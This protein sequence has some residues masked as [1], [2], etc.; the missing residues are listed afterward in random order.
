MVEKK[1]EGTKLQVR[2]SGEEM[3]TRRNILDSDK[4]LGRPYVFRFQVVGIDLNSWPPLH[5]C[6]TELNC[7][8]LSLRSEKLAYSSP[9]AYS[10]KQIYFL[11]R[12]DSVF[13]R[14]VWWWWCSTAERPV[15]VLDVI[16]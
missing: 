12:M 14:P 5:F 6:S 10:F 13:F 1:R 7:G 2:A 4:M 3:F 11:Q 8:S 16:P 9:W 15:L